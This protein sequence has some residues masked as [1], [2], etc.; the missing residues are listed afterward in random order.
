MIVTGHFPGHNIIILVSPDAPIFSHQTINR[1]WQHRKRPRTET[2]GKLTTDLLPGARAP[3]S[4]SS[5]PSSCSHRYVNPSCCRP[6]WSERSGRNASPEIQEFS[7]LSSLLRFTKIRLCDNR[8]KAKIF[9]HVCH[10]FFDIFCLLFDLFRF[11]SRFHLVWLD[12]NIAE[13]H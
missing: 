6:G 12:L 13:K 7:L 4:S 2:I 5:V 8:A 3:A 1:K 10:L 9:F 11:C